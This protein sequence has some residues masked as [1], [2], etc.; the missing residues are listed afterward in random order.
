MDLGLDRFLEMF[1]A[2]FGRFT[3]TV[4]L[5]VIGL[6]LF[7]YSIRL[8]IETTIYFYHLAASAVG[9]SGETGLTI[10]IKIG[11]LLVQMLLV[12][13]LGE[14]LLRFYYRPAMHRIADQELK[15]IEE[16]RSELREMMKQVEDA[17]GQAKSFAAEA[18]DKYRNVEHLLRESEE[19]LMR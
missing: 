5:A 10:T 11:L 16:R 14:A 13:L 4:L 17:L 19:K 12:I 15:R 3:T 6:A 9:L 1:E 2:R 7:G 8:F 18:G